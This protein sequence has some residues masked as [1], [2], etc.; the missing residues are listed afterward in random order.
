MDDKVTPEQVQIITDLIE[1][2]KVKIYLREEGPVLATA[3]LI[4][5]GL[6]EING[7]TIRESKYEEN[8]LWIQ[9]PAFG[10]KYAKSFFI[11]DKNIWS[12]VIEKI[13][14]SYK[15]AREEKGIAD[16]VENIGF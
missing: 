13:D 8:E 7:F 5:G 6:V 14:R 3:Q 16:E 4:I 2:S 11:K 1:K 15:N 12:I 9:P 10:I